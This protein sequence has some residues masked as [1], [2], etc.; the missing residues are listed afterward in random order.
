MVVVVDAVVESGVYIRM[1]VKLLLV[2]VCIWVALGSRPLVG[3][4]CCL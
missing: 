4:V 3:V 2:P 1:W